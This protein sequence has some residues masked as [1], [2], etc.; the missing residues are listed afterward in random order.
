MINCF[1]LRKANCVP[2]KGC[3]WVSK[4]LCCQ[5]INRN[6]KQCQKSL[7]FSNYRI[8]VLFWSLKLC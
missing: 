5:C 7:K 1:N 8:D 3:M 4:L 2:L 6:L